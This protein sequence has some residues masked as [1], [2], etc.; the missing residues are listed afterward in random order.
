M[1]YTPELKTLTRPSKEFSP[2]MLGQNHDKLAPY[3]D[4]EDTGRGV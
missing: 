4:D 1:A 2:K 3:T